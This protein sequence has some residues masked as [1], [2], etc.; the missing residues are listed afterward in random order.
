VTTAVIFD[1]DGTLA[2]TVSWLELTRG[3]GADPA[4][5]AKIFADYQAR[6]ITYEQSKTQLLGLWHATGQAD[7]DTVRQLFKSWPLHEAA[8][9]L[10]DYVKR[11]GWRPCLITGSVDLY[12]EVVAGKLGI[13]DWFANTTLTFNA[14]GDL[15]DYDYHRDQ[16]AEKVRHFEYF[17][18]KYR[19]DPGNCLA[20]GDSDNDLLLFRQ[21][22][23]ILL[24]VE[25]QSP[26]LHDAAW[27]VVDRL[28]EVTPIIETLDAPP[29]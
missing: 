17:C 20:I 13:T 4:A 16:A 11:R 3:L 28:G 8:K 6:T 5:H 25:G 26:E 24:E 7:R 14:A 12:A 19:L 10:V 2:P 27:Q 29:K 1:L 21:C 15:T 18:T 9:P 23:G 22:R